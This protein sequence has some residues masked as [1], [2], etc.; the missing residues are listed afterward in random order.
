MDQLLCYSPSTMHSWPA[1]D[2]EQILAVDGY[3]MV[4]ARRNVADISRYLDAHAAACTGAMDDS[5]P[6]MAA[7]TFPRLPGG[8][9]SA[10]QEMQR[11]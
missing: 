2:R 6:L 4:I 9:R 10:L 1:E 11:D 7:E 5:I 3:D 8:I